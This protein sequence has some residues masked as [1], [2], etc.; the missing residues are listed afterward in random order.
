MGS[1]RS[2]LLLPRFSTFLR[3]MLCMRLH[4]V[5]S[6]RH[7]TGIASHLCSEQASSSLPDSC[8][9]QP[10]CPL[11]KD[12]WADSSDNRYRPLNMSIPDRCCRYS[13][14]HSTRLCA[15]PDSLKC[16]R[17]GWNQ[18]L[19]ASRRCLQPLRCRCIELIRH[20]SLNTTRNCQL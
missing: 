11:L 2:C 1:L 18:V 12:S 4:Q 8:C 10:Q 15:R 14:S 6:S 19:H 17:K 3:H 20:Q 13:G 7:C 16:F 9:N 5:Q